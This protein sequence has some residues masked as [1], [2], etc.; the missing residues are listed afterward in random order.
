M[1][2]RNEQEQGKTW[3]WQTIGENEGTQDLGL[4]YFKGT[5][6]QLVLLGHDFSVLFETWSWCIA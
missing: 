5:H 6:G 3:P 1:Y 4:V 2:R